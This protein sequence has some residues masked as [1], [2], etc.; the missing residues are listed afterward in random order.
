MVVNRLRSGNIRETLSTV[1]YVWSTSFLE[2]VRLNELSAT[3]EAGSIGPV[4]DSIDF[5]WGHFGRDTK[6]QLIRN[7]WL[8]ERKSPW[9]QAVALASESGQERDQIFN[10][11][12][13][14]ACSDLTTNLGVG[15]G[16]Q[17]TADRCPFD[18]QSMRWDEPETCLAKLKS[19]V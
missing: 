6:I 15:R 14:V 8:S 3:M 18:D 16:G 19:T 5:H 1:N 12:R 9:Q 2:F 17:L 7:H 13:H 11:T 10:L 4:S